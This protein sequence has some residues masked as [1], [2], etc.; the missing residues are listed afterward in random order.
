MGNIFLKKHFS[1]AKRNWKSEETQIKFW[2]KFS[3]NS[4]KFMTDELPSHLSNTKREFVHLQL[5]ANKWIKHFSSKS[6]RGQNLPLTEKTF[7]LINE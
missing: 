5:L 6:W 1:L 7:F 3:L 4:K 2:K